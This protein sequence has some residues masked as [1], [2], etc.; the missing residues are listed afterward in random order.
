MFLKAE[1]LSNSL[2]FQTVRKGDVQT[3]FAKSRKVSSYK[4]IP[5][6]CPPHITW[7]LLTRPL[8]SVSMGEVLLAGPTSPL[9]H[10]SG[11]T[12]HKSVSVHSPYHLL[13]P[14]PCSDM[15]PFPG[16][17]M[18]EYQEPWSHLLTG[19][20]SMSHR[21]MPL[22][23]HKDTWAIRAQ[24]GQQMPDLT[25]WPWGQWVLTLFETHHDTWEGEMGVPKIFG[26]PGSA[27]SDVGWT[28][29]II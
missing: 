26:I 23:D 10:L 4:A 16:P 20:T 15:P 21:D 2:H 3:W 18:P 14:S 25:V 9:P 19:E 29:L 8:E 27:S 11:L 6:A 12:K 13:E 22:C 1:I 17:R 5:S 24:E 28:M 7:K